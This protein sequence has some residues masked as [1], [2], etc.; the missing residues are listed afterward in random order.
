[1]QRLRQPS[2]QKVSTATSVREKYPPRAVR[3]VTRP[4]GS[5]VHSSLTPLHPA[6][7][8]SR[9]PVHSRCPR[10]G[11]THDTSRGHDGIY[12]LR[13]HSHSIGPR[14]TRAMNQRCGDRAQSAVGR[15]GIYPVGAPCHQVMAPVIPSSRR[16][17]GH[18]EPEYAPGH[19]TAA[20]P[21]QAAG[22]WER[23]ESC[24][25]K[26]TAVGGP[27]AIAPRVWPTA[28]AHGLQI[29]RQPIGISRPPAMAE[30]G[31][32]IHPSAAFGQKRLGRADG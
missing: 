31:K 21:G 12:A 11:E 22:T 30:E 10:S 13:S 25:I 4:A 6:Q 16:A 9:H 18:R 27:H 26:P 2:V 17:D 28:P 5:A 14:H 24:R 32:S 15:H 29:R 19:I 23:R 1:M 8:A 3:T 7:T 20:D